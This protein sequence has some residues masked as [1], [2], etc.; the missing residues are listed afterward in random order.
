MTAATME[1]QDD[2]FIL[3]LGDDENRFNPESCAAIE[4]AL[5]EVEVAPAPRALVT[6]A[7]GKFWS[8]GLDLEWLGAHTDRAQ[9][10]IDQ[11][12]RLLAAF[13]GAGVPTVAAVQGHAF[14][15]GAMFATAHDITVMRADRGYWCLPEADLGMAFTPGMTGLLQARLPRRAAREAMLTARRY[16]APDAVVA[17][18]I[19]EAVAEEDVLARAVERATALAPK[20][21]D[22]LRTIKHRMHAGTLRALTASQQL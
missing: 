4:E 20:T 9:A 11:Y 12:H 7:T 1:R 6:A 15:A 13:L 19:D 21:P 3:N 18:I 10:A 8:N 22:T 14:A 17:G 2:V 16:G 5:A